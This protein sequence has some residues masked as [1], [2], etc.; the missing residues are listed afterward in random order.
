MRAREL[1]EEFPHVRASDSALVAARAMAEAGRPGIVVLDDDGRPRTV[2]PGSQV[3]RFVI[4]RY[5]QEDPALCRVYD[6]KTADELFGRLRDQQV[7]DLLP[8]RKD[9]DEIPVVDPDATSIE[10]AAV[11][12]RMRSP[13]AVVADK[14][15]VIGVITVSRLLRLL[16]PD[17]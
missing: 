3:L 14:E 13:I 6:E 10:V 4:P 17:E 5:V 9:H 12:A 8:D 1:A 7:K 15:R 16:L 11:M 2:L